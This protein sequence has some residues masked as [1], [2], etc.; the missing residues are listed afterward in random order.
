M[1]DFSSRPTLRETHSHQM[2][3]SF[4]VYREMIQAKLDALLFDEDAY[5]WIRSRIKLQPCQVLAAKKFVASTVKLLV[6]EGVGI[7]PGL[8]NH[9][10]IIGIEGPE[11]PIVIPLELREQ[12]EG[13]PE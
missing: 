12:A 3:T 13:I 7:R 1:T 2:A 10:A 11:D 4:T 5:S 9:D 6:D 8:E